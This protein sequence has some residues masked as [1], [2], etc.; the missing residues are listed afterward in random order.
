MTPIVF[1]VLGTLFTFTPFTTSLQYLFPELPSSTAQAITDDWF[2]SSQRDFTYLSLS[3]RYTPIAEVLKASLPRVLLMNGLTP[4]ENLGPIMS[5]FQSL[6]ARSGFAEA[7]RL[8]TSTGKYKLVAATN[9]GLDST[10]GLLRGALGD[11]AASKW[12]VFSC[13]EIKVAKPNKEVYEKVWEKIGGKEQSAWF[14][15]SH[16]WD[17]LAAKNA[18]FKTLFLT[19]EEHLP[20]V[21]IW[22]TPDLVAA[23]FVE[24]IQA[25]IKADNGL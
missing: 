16:T 25:I 5:N 20:L 15:A 18:G 6:P 19:Y 21:E 23:G 17:L 12:D 22:G 13:D 2:H 11:S 9:G 7:V 24:G 10:Q 4:P 3:G 1:D 8:L 14:V